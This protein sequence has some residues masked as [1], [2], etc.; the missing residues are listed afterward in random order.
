MAVDF[1][2]FMITR[3][4]PNIK[5]LLEDKPKL[6]EFIKNTKSHDAVVSVLN[7]HK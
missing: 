5:F 2:L 6:S 7:S 4:D 3:W 1:Y